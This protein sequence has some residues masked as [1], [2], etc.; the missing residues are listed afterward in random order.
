MKL[1]FVRH[2]ETRFNAERRL[3]GQIDLPLTILGEQQ[4]QAV[5]K[6]LAG[7]QFDLLLSSTLLRARRTAEIIAQTSSK[8]FETDNWLNERFCGVLEGLTKQEMKKRF[9]EA[10]KAYKNRRLNL[11]IEGGGET[12]QQFYLRVATGMKE[13]ARTNI[14]KTVVAV[15]HGGTIKEAFNLVFDSCENGNHLRSGNCSIS[16]FHYQEDQWSMETWG[17]SSHLW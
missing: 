9:P 17:D 8:T 14:N 10:R 4:A 16:I 15:C 2:G 6:K 1:I 11:T 13:L 3:T 12:S 5:G 7:I